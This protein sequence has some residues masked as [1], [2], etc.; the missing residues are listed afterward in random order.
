MTDRRQ[1][2]AERAELPAI[3]FRIGREEFGLRLAAIR[4]IIKLP[5]ITRVPKAAPYVKGVINL[6]G[7]VIPVIDIGRRLGI[8]ETAQTETARILVVESGNETVGL[9]AEEVSKITRIAAADIQPPPPLVGGVAADF[10]EGVVHLPKR[11]L[12]F[13]NLTRILAEDEHDDPAKSEPT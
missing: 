2:L 11:F 5:R 8:G 6:H 13:L 1:T 12:V 3:S 10:L 7:D 9:L 4:E